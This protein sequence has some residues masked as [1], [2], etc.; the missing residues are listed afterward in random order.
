MKYFRF[1]ADYGSKALR[2]KS[3][4]GGSDAPNVL[5]LYTDENQYV[6]GYFGCIAA[7]FDHP[8]SGVANTATSREYLQT[9]C[10]RI[11]EAVARKVHPQMFAFLD[12]PE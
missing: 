4:K 3:V 2:R 1:Y 7:V 10:K 11:S 6:N 5:A 8:D 9:N 12:Q